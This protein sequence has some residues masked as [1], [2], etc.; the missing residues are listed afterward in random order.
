[1]NSSH[2]NNVPRKDFNSDIVRQGKYRSSW[3]RITEAIRTVGI[4]IVVN[5]L[6]T[7]TASLVNVTMKLHLALA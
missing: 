4:T 3:V 5:S 1:M 7:A 2:R 6:V